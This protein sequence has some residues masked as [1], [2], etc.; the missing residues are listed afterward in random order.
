M[1]VGSWE[2]EGLL[3]TGPGIKQLPDGDGR[4]TADAVS[5]GCP[6]AT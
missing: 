1:R 2:G 6:L 5:V 4:R 3:P